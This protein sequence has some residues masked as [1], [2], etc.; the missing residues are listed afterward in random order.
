MEGQYIPFFYGLT[1]QY[2]VFVS[3]SSSRETRDLV[4]GE[5]VSPSPSL[6]SKLEDQVSVFMTSGDS[7]AQ[8]YPQPMST[9]GP[10]EGHFL[11]SQ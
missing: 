8:L 10:R 2:R 11:H 6:L 4:R 7:L 3:C 1:A 5:V 9:S